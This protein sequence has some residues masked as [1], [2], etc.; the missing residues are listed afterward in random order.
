MLQNQE[1]AKSKYRKEH[2]A[3]NIQW[4]GSC[5]SSDWQ[6]NSMRWSVIGRQQI[7]NGSAKPCSMWRVWTP[8]R[9]TFIEGCQQELARKVANKQRVHSSVGRRRPRGMNPA[10]LMAE[11]NEMWLSCRVWFVGRGCQAMM[12]QNGVT[13]SLSRGGRGPPEAVVVGSTNA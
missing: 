3:Q 4:L 8:E 1:V 2:T 10:Q 6:T 9:Y 12:E 7:W 11:G 13:L 5:K